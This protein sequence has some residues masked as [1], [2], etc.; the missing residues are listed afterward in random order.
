M[1]PSEFVRRW[2]TAGAS[3]SERAAGQSH[4]SDLCLVLGVPNP[5][6]GDPTGQTYNSRPAWLAALHDDLDR[7]VHAAYG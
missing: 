3:L 6:A 7:A 1:T 4:S 5:A 2:R